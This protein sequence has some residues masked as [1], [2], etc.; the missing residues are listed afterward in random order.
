MGSTIGYTRTTCDKRDVISLE[1]RLRELSIAEP[2]EH[3]VTL[4]EAV[5]PRESN[6]AEII[7][8]ALSGK[9]RTVS[10]LPGVPILQ[11]LRVV[12]DEIKASF[13]P[14][15]TITR[16]AACEMLRLSA[17]GIGSLLSY[18][19]VK[20]EKLR[21]WR[22][23]TTIGGRSTGRTPNAFVARTCRFWSAAKFPSVRKPGLS[24]NASR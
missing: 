5:R 20:A 23:R 22:S 15:G 18:G 13:F 14:A 1:R 3:Q 21:S 4:W 11:G 8:T 17:S 24:S 7:R 2:N 16:A 12:V 19:C 9:L 6:I 10:A